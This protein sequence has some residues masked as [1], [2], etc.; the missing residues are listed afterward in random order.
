MV[1]SCSESVICK[2]HAFIVSYIIKVHNR[3]VYLLFSLSHYEV[4]QFGFERS[5]YTASEGDNDVEVCVVMTGGVL[6]RFT[7]QVTVT[8]EDDTATGSDILG[9]NLIMI[10]YQL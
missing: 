7:V 1:C 3:C 8:T 2:V 6:E 10:C 5:S 4:V 9:K